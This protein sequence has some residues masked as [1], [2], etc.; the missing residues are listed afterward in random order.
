MEGFRGVTSGYPK[1]I[2]FKYLHEST[3]AA[4]KITGKKKKLKYLRCFSGVKGPSDG[5]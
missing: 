5:A 1:K 4:C 2:I 3:Q